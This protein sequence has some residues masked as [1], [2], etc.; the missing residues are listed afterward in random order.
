M[1][2]VALVVLLAL[3]EY[4]FFMAQCGRARGRHGIKAP[5]VTGH[6]E[7]ERLLRIQQNTLEQLVVFVPAIFLFA[8]YV[9]AAAAA[10][11]GVVFIA[12][13]GLYYHAYRADPA[14]R[15]PGMLLSFFSNLALVLGAVFGVSAALLGY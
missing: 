8:L 4:I 3:I 14:T 12:G 7:F 13:R 15:G 2:L 6:P 11:I 1:D 10:L 9:N 5:A